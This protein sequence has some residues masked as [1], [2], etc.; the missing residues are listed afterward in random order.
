MAMEVTAPVKRNLKA[1][2]TLFFV[3]PLVA[4]FL[5]GDL[6]LKLLPALIVLAPMYGGA[7]V[8][9]REIVRRK[10]RGW[11]SMLLLGAAYA[12]IE[13]GFVTQS[14][15]NHDYLKMHMHLLDPAY[16]PALGIGAWWTLLML[17]VHTFWSI[18]VS[19]ALVEALVPEAAES[20]WLGG[21]G[22]A[23]VGA[24]F[25]LGLAANAGFQL[26][27]DSF[28]ASHVQFLSVGVVSIVL[29]VAALLLPVRKVPTARGFVPSP[30][31]TALLTLMLGLAVMQTP[32]RL[33]WWAVV[34][35]LAGDAIFLR[36]A[37]QLSRRSGWNGLN[38]FSFAAAGAVAYGL[39]AFLQKPLLP[40]SLVMARVGNAVFLAAAIAVIVVGAKRTSRLTVSPG[41]GTLNT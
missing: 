11:P 1:V 18:G 21:A 14:L 31:V 24:I 34:I 20:P 6:P 9:I 8:L 17:N 26:K 32:P 35:M 38:T 3:A 36:L 19:I 2:I 30:W 13:E 16:I 40:G 39:H 33:E 10:G 7:A 28:R 29:I 12:L 22:D 27:Q 37:A 41:G 4:E 23:V 25:L 15:F 5:L